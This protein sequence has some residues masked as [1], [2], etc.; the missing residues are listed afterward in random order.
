MSEALEHARQAFAQQA[1]GAAFA[2][3]SA[4]QEQTPL[5]P[6]DLERLAVAAYLLGRDDD[7]AAAWERAHN[8]HVGRDKPERAARCAF[9][10]GLGLVDRG[11]PARGGGWIARAG[12]LLEGRPA[13]AAHGY[14]LLAASLQALVQGDAEAAYGSFVEAA[15][16]RE[17]FGDTDLMTLG[18]LG[19]GQSLLRFGDVGD[20]VALLD[21]VMVAVTS[22]EVSPIVVGLVYCAVIEACGEIFDLRRGQEW[23]EALTHWCAAQP[24]LVPYRGQCLVHRAEIMLRHGDWRDAGEEARHA[25][26]RL[27]RRPAAGAA[28]YLQAELHRLRGEFAMAEAGYREASHCGRNAQ[29]GLAL[30]R[31]AQGDIASAQAAIRRV[32]AEERD[33]LA[34]SGLLAAAV[35]IRLAAGDVPAARGAADELAGIAADL[36]VP[37]LLALADLMQGAVLLAEGEPADACVTLRRAWTAWSDLAVPYEAARTRTLIGRAC[38]E[39]GDADTAALEL[40]A[41]RRGFVQLGATPDVER[42][43]ALAP[44]PVA[45]AGQAG[46][47]P[48]ELEVLRL[49]AAGET[50]RAIAG[51]LVISEKTVARHVSNIFTKLGLSTRSAATAYAYEHGL[52]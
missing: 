18:R 40:D 15:A 6:A 7:S 22:G 32:V 9:W 52:V 50:N 44:R 33:R 36:D 37:F 26:E 46:L 20:G 49:V 51:A 41:A 29:P 13:C 24:D 48:R 2:Q 23:T 34:R 39:L 25:C 11:E 45:Q 27:S 21:E 1:W 47:S 31:L 17:R 30:L 42:I 38:R 43:D 5:E 19:Q 8:E 10:L 28:F 12:R 3:L 14:L 4:A 35:E 16:L